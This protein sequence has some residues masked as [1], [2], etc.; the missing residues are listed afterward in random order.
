MREFTIN[1]NDS[2]QRIDRFITKLMPALPQ[3]MLYKG[4][5]KNCVKL[6]GK[7]IKDGSVFVKEGDV[8]NLYFSDEFFESKS[9]FNYV[10]ADIDVVYEDDNIIIV[11]KPSGVIAHSDTKNAQT[12][13]I[14]MIKSYLYDNGEYDEKAENSFSPSLCNRLDRNTAGLVIAA[15]N[16]AA[17]RDMNA[18][19]RNR[20]VRKFYTAQV[21]GTPPQSGHLEGYAVRDRMVTSITEKKQD[22]AKAVSL[23][24]RVTARRSGGA[25]LEIELHTGRTHQIRAQLAAVGYPLVGDTKYG[26]HG[27]KYR[28]ALRAVRLEF[29][30]SDTDSILGYLSG[31]KIKL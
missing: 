8:V 24:Y 28:Q 16:A 15:K 13:L 27:A 11:N 4:L 26:G 29:D 2:G 22:G 19:I 21:E 3:S 30:F 6:N 25:T 5:R 12:T 9:S 14:D 7:H 1:K 23:D 31:K 20:E 10:R 17:L 18:R